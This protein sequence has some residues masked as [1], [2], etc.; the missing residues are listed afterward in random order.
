[1][2]VIDKYTIIILIFMAPFVIGTVA[3]VVF[4]I[5]RLIHDIYIGIRHGIETAYRDHENNSDNF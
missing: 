5:V 3:W 1:M 2:F 4:G